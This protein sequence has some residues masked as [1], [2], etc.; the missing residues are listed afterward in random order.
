MGD[1][2]ASSGA[3]WRKLF[4]GSSD[5]S[6]DFCPSDGVVAPP[7]DVFDEGSQVWRFALVGQ[8]LGRA[9]SF[10]A[11][12]KIAGILWGKQGAVEVSS[13]GENLVVFRFV[14][15]TVR[16]WVFENG[17]W[18]F[19]NKPL[20][21]RRWEPNLSSLDFKLDRLP[22]WFHLWGIPLEL[23]SRRG[24]SYIASAI[25]CPLYM[26]STTASRQRLAYAKV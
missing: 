25:G 7:A 5:Q 4:V 15:S 21:L 14:N 19:Q 20:I 1:C 3:D 13:V 16:D 2:A 23:F 12:Q 10:G 18:H 24:L 22:V 11:L 9:P 8:F 6:L 17:P 26:D